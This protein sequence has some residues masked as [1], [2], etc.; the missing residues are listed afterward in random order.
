MLRVALSLAAARAATVT[1]GAIISDANATLYGRRESF[2]AQLAVDAVNADSTLLA[3]HHLELRIVDDGGSGWT[4]MRAA[5]ELMRGGVHALIG[6]SYSSTSLSVLGLT[7]PL[8]V[9]LLSYSATSPS[10]GADSGHGYF[11]RVVPSDA[12]QGPAMISVVQHHNWT[13]VCILFADNTY[14]TSGAIETQEAATR[15]GIKVLSLQSYD[16]TSKNATRALQTLAE[17]GCRIFLNWCGGTSATDCRDVMGQ[18]SDA[19]LLRGGDFVWLLSDGC[20]NGIG[21]EPTM[22]AG[23]GD[24]LV[25]TLCL[26]P[27]PNDNGAATRTAAR[28]ALLDSWPAS[29]GSSPPIYASFL[30]DGVLAAARALHAAP[31]AALANPFSLGAAGACV[32]DMA[33]PAAPWEHG[34]AVRAAL[35]TLSFDGA[36]AAASRPVALTPNLERQHSTYSLHNLQHWPG[37]GSSVGTFQVVGAVHVTRSTASAPATAA[38]SMSAAVQWSAT[39][40]P[41]APVPSD[42]LPREVCVV[43]AIQE[44][45]VYFVGE[46]EDPDCTAARCDV[47]SEQFSCPPSCYRGLAIDT[48]KQVAFHAGFS[49]RIHHTPP[50]GYT[51]ILRD[52]LQPR[53]GQSPA[54][55]ALGGA[56]AGHSPM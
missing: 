21:Y 40:G 8:K 34:D 1:I 12:A 5:C 43:V 19:G 23:F 33:A 9:P 39:D 36:T 6:P 55:L 51:Q 29:H 32:P 42:V 2:A 18:A 16:A 30:Y 37:V 48:L 3:G 20:E 4:A 44:P 45:Y 46:D 38:V 35:A 41:Y 49:Y 56:T 7:T 47:A 26:V 24:S 17:S 22:Y 28:Q 11:A 14:A 53:H 10:L 52:H 15:A 13:Q 25:G 54:V 50:A 31:A 27:S